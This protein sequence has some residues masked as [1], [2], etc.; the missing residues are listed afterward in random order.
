MISMLI[1]SS[2]TRIFG[3]GLMGDAPVIGIAVEAI[4]E[5]L[6]MAAALKILLSSKV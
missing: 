6:L 2:L 4:L 5:V 1:W 3:A